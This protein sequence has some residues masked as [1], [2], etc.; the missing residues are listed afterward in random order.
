[1]PDL[2]TAPVLRAVVIVTLALCIGAVLAVLR[3]HWRAYRALPRHA[4]LTPLHVMLVSSGVLIVQGTLAWALID[5]F[6][7]TVTPVQAVRTALYGV[8]SL[9]IL[10]A[11]FVVGG[12]QRRRVRFTPRCTT[13]T[14]H[15]EATVQL[16][17]TEQTD[18]T[19]D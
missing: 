14:V 3:L 10:A 13:V 12:L 8:G 4:G 19:R 2:L 6:A 17:A 5:G 11:L 1:M 18:R 15:D 16:D 7:N 9:I